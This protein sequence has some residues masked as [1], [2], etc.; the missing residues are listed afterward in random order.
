MR[1]YLQEN[2]QLAGNYPTEENASSLLQLLNV[3]CSQGRV[4]SSVSNGAAFMPLPMGQ[5]LCRSWV[6]SYTWR[7][8]SHVP[9]L[10]LDLTLSLLHLRHFLRLRCG[11]ADVLCRVEHS[12]DTYSQ[13]FDKSRDSVVITI[14][15]GKPCPTK[16]RG[17]SNLLV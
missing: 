12:I 10:P 15:S 14:N 17:S 16:A 8:A 5:I 3:I 6:M 4:R 11:D 1:G 2:E 13:N 9:S 7:T